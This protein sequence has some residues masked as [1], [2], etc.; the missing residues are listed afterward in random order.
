MLYRP[1][2]QSLQSLSA[3][4]PVASLYLPWPQ[5]VQ[6]LVLWAVKV[7]YLPKAQAVQGVPELTSRPTAEDQRPTGQ[8]LQDELELCPAWLPYLPAMQFLQL[9]AVAA[10]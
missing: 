2:V 4:C 8:A 6:V 5:L 7:L 10:F 3:S 9:Y 1:A